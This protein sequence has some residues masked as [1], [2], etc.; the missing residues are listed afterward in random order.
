MASG[1]HHALGELVQR[2]VQAA[3]FD[4]EELSVQAAGRRRSVRVVID[5]DHGV[6]L[7]EAADVSRLL[8][9]Q[10]DPL[11]GPADPMGGDPYTLE[12]TSPGI[13]RPLTLPRHFRRA[14]GRLLT[15]TLVDGRSFPGRVLRADD[16]RVDLL[17]GPKGTALQTIPLEQIAKAKVEV[18]FNPPPEQVRRLLA[19]AGIATAR[20]EPIELDP[21]GSADPAA[22]DED[23]DPDYEA[24]D[25]D[26]A[27]D[28]QK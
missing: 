12:V 17:T 6:G 11:D 24:E 8:S 9:E 1:P 16:T 14:A 19:E 25:D 5:S 27:E 2:V 3:G 21:E 26:I 13:G 28:E 20:D 7:D 23:E 4:L 18:E 15:V 22:P 10:L